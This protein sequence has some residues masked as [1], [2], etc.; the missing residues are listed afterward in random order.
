[1]FVG[2]DVRLDDLTV[3]RALTALFPDTDIR[4]LHEWLESADG[5]GPGIAYHVTHDGTDF[6]TVVHLD[7]FP[8]GPSTAAGIEL[9]RRLAAHLGCRTVCG[10]TGHGDG[11]TPYWSIMWVDGVSYLVDDA[12]T[13]FYDG[14]GGALVPPRPVD[15]TGH[16]G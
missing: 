3:H 1:V 15:L 5:T 8:G 6:P 16:G 9:A 14:V 2:F 12:D 13:A 7:V 4:D 11:D 10:G